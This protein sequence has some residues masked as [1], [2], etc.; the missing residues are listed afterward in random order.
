[1]CTLINALSN[2]QTNQGHCSKPDA[3]YHLLLVLLETSQACTSCASFVQH[4]YTILTAL[5][6]C[7]AEELCAA[8]QIWQDTGRQG[9]ALIMFNGELD[10]IRAGGYYPAFIYPELAKM[11]NDFIPKFEA[12]YYIHNFKGTRPG[13][14]GY[15]VYGGL[16]PTDE[17]SAALTAARA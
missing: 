2:E 6:V 17:V 9:R 15:C 5:C 7:I 10:R 8:Q 16:S 11:A 1:M 4:S 12:A 14:E 13:E 3:S